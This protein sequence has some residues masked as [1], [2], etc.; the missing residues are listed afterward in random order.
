[1]SG[2]CVPASPG[3]SPDK[4]MLAPRQP[5]QSAVKYCCCSAC[6]R[7]RLTPFPP[8]CLH[9]RCTRRFHCCQLGQLPGTWRLVLRY[10]WA[11]AAMGESLV[12]LRKRTPRGWHRPRSPEGNT[13]LG[14]RGRHPH[15]LPALKVTAATDSTAP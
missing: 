11:R 6:N 14:K 9:L 13:E 15:F 1:M 7:G 10:E 8:D 5:T 2:D 12:E 4:V 3:N